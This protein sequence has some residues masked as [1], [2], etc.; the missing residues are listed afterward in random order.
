MQGTLPFLV[1]SR[2]IAV[3]DWGARNPLSPGRT[4]VAGGANP[5][6]QRSNRSCGHLE[7]SRSNYGLY[8]DESA[9]A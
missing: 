2:A 4:E 9:E 3:M 5:N 8:T 7:I 6:H 1:V